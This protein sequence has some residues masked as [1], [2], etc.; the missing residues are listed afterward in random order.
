[1]GRRAADGPFDERQARLAL[2]R[3]GVAAAAERTL[4]PL[5]PLRRWSYNAADPF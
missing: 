4:D 5:L 1:M 2:S 3:G